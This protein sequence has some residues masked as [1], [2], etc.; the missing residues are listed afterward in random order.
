M[1]DSNYFISY[2]GNCELCDINYCD[3]CYY[4]KDEGIY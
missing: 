1:C 4:G 3:H 2:D